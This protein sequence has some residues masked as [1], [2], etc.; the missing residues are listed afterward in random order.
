M[1]LISE[2]LDYYE[3]VSRYYRQRKESA[4][5]PVLLQIAV[6]YIIENRIGLSLEKNFDSYITMIRNLENPFSLYERKE[7]ASF[8]SSV[9]ESLVKTDLQPL[10]IFD[11]RGCPSKDSGLLH[12][13]DS[14]EN[15][16]Y[17]KCLNSKA[18]KEVYAAFIAL[19]FKRE[20]SREDVL[21]TISYLSR[22]DKEEVSAS[23]ARLFTE[24][25]QIGSGDYVDVA[26]KDSSLFTSSLSCLYPLEMEREEVKS[27][28]FTRLAAFIG[29]LRSSH[30][31]LEGRKKALFIDGELTAVE[32][33]LDEYGHLV[34]FSSSALLLSSREDEEKLRSYLIDRRYIDAV[35]VLP[36][37][38]G[39]EE[40]NTVILMLDKQEKDSILLVDLK[41]EEKNRK[42]FVENQLTRFA[43]NWIKDAYENRSRSTDYSIVVNYE[44]LNK[45]SNLVPRNYMRREE[46]LIR[47]TDELRYRIDSRYE[48]LKELLG[49]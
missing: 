15:E 23:L 10:E 34:F 36:K 7:L 38:T 48:A 29:D 6:R 11:R 44:N 1:K 2:I 5:T 32:R 28:L 20:G 8:F 33:L 3:E 21:Y 46:R 37:L 35:I 18:F 39:L 25:L 26:M 19:D 49:L 9:D 13:I 17:R 43:L 12:M 4:L 24:L 16:E 14:T 40:K 27:D 31:V 45:G 41:S 42:Y 22:K 30:M 47:S